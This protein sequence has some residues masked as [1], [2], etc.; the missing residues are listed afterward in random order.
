MQDR[1]FAIA[2]TRDHRDHALMVQGTSDA[3]RVVAPFGDHPLHADRFASQQVSPFTS[4]VLPGVKTERSGRPRTSTS[5]WLF[6]FRP[7]RGISMASV[8]VPPLRQPAYDIGKAAAL[9]RTANH[10]RAHGAS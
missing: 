2:P 10:R 9:L 6:V 4:D 8:R 1:A 7:P 3:D 5:A